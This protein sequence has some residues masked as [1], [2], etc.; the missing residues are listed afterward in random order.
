MRGSSIEI[1][2]ERG[3]G[4]YTGIHFHAL[5]RGKTMRGPIVILLSALLLLNALPLITGGLPEAGSTRTGGRTLFVS[6]TGS[7]WSSVNRAIE[8]AT[9]GDTIMIA[10]GNYTDGMML[11]KDGIDISVVA[12][13][14]EMFG[15]ASVLYP[16]L[17]LSDVVLAN[18]I[19][20]VLGFFASLSPAWFASRLDPVRA[21]TKV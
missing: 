1:G 11:L 4:K 16:A 5:K 19:V 13:G 15:A 12:E 10:P 9:A 8:N 6:E 2:Q 17:Y 21:I 7:T 18:L 20:I 14:M 3:N